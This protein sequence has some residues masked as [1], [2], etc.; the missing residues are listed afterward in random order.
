[1]PADSPYVANLAALWTS[2]PTLARAIE[3]LPEA[4]MYPISPSKAG[5]PTV[6]VQCEG[7]TL[8]L[9]SRHNP[10]DEA[11]RLI[12]SIDLGSA[13]AFHVHGFGLG[14]HVERL[15]DRAGDEA[16]V[17]VFEP[18]LVVLRTAMWHRDL[19]RLLGAGRVMFFWRED[20]ADLLGRLTPHT[21][22]AS[23]GIAMVGHPPSMQAQREF[24]LRMQRRMT[25]FAAYC[26]TSITTL[27]V[28]GRRTAENIARNIGWYAA[29]PSL[30]RL[31]DRYRG[32]PAIIVSA[33]PSLRKNIHLL[34]AAQE[35]AVL[36]A[37]QTTLRPL[38]DLGVEPHFVTALDYHDIC[39]RFYENLPATLR[40]ELVAEPKA[41]DRIFGMF[42]G[43]VTLLGN[44][45]AQGLLAEMG[46]ERFG[47]TSGATVAHL[48]YYLAEHLGCDPIIFVGQDLGF[49]DGLCYAPGTS[50]EDV[51]RPEISRFCTMEM[52]QW[53]Q[54]VRDRAILR[55][56][57]DHEHRL[58]YTEERL[59]TYLQQFERDFAGSTRRIIDA[60]E[61]G[62]LKRGAAPMALERALSQFC[63]APVAWR[64]DDHPGSDWTPLPAVRDCLSRRRGEAER[65][66][67]IG[68]Q[69]LPLLAEVRDHLDDQPRV[70]RAIARIDALRANMNDLGRTYE[71]ILQLTQLS[72]L[73]RFGQD[74]RLGAE[75]S[76]D[77]IE[78][79]RRQV[80]RDIAN[81][82][83]V[84][85]ASGQF[86][87]MIDEVI[88]TIGVG[89]RREA[90]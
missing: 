90:A 14:Y 56:I 59:F 61:G 65:I 48:A 62:A 9:H 81:V 16:I 55:R 57:E 49:S 12:G 71:L 72:E 69:T 58:M 68:H 60:S 46:L 13:M 39:T 53:E 42:P 21:A 80:L 66:A 32:E 54:I 10:V 37:V 47:L 33:G 45:Y 27:I 79:Q 2:D 40:T 77:A 6:A 29:C 70:N 87:S 35:R 52:K 76:L 8:Y 41:T 64:H 43:A 51:W 84:A 44:S 67:A 19:S 5:P 26:R 15:F 89:A 7:R 85:E 88:A 30:G 1:M 75:R 78:R 74:R 31:K 25:E 86:V 4:A 20:G 23:L 63:R 36:V 28:N 50:Y 38:L 3:A 24:H 22:M 18:D 11:D 83:A 34:K 73:Q 17:C 82:R